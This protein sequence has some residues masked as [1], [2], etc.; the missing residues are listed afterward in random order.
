MIHIFLRRFTNEC[1]FFVICKN[2]HSSYSSF[3]TPAVKHQ[4]RNQQTAGLSW[5]LV[6]SLHFDCLAA[7]D[8]QQNN[9]FVQATC[10]WNQ[11]DSC[12]D[13]FG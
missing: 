3:H 1:I 5:Y 2:I 7:L 6:G 4:Q 8:L 13:V 12:L 10:E 9:F 11:S